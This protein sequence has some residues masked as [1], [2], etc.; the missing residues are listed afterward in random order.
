MSTLN[1][2]ELSKLPTPDVL[3]TLS[4][5]TVLKEIQDDFLKIAPE[6]EEVINLE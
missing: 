3:E 2:I 4:F 5:E 1:Q 6:F